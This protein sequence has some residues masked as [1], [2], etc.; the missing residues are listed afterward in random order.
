MSPLLKR[1]LLEESLN[2]TLSEFQGR[3]IFV[4][5]AA[6]PRADEGD[7]RSGRSGPLGGRGEP[8]VELDWG[9]ARRTQAELPRRERDQIE[10]QEKKDLLVQIWI[11]VQLDQNQ[12]DYHQE[13]DH[14]E[15]QEN[16]SQEMNQIWIGGCQVGINWIASKRK[17]PQRPKRTQAKRRT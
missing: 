14:I 1:E 8:E 9:S 15:V 5:V 11:G 13:K 10:V 16:I 6:P 12:V 17:I 4:N 2:L 7:W 3:K